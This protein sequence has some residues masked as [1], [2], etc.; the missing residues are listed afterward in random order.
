MPSTTTYKIV[1]MLHP[2]C[3]DLVSVVVAQMLRQKMSFFAKAQVYLVA[4]TS[5]GRLNLF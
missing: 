2:P 5:V 1:G 4:S 3:C